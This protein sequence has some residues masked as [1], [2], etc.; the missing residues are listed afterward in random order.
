MYDVFR[1]VGRVVFGSF[2]AFLE[3]SGSGGIIAIPPLVEPTFRTRQLST[4]VLNLVLGKVF[5]EGLVTTLFSMLGHGGFLAKLLLSCPEDT[6][7]SMSWHT[8]CRVPGAR[9]AWMRTRQCTR[10]AWRCVRWRTQ[11]RESVSHQSSG[12]GITTSTLMGVHRRRS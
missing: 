8:S 11:E 2:G 12:S 5:G 4:E 9:Q 6:V 7:F 10:H 1:R 3:P